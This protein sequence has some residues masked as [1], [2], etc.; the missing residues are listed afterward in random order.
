MVTR[1]VRHEISSPASNAVRASPMRFLGERSMVRGV[2]RSAP[3]AFSSSGSDRSSSKHIGYP[4][5]SMLLQPSFGT[6]LT[7]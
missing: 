1:T 2:L 4:S 5:I 7:E 3:A 6:N